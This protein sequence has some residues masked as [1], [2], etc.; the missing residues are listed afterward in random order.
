[1]RIYRTSLFYDMSKNEFK[2]H[3]TVLKASG[4]SSACFYTDVQK[5]NTFHTKCILFVDTVFQDPRCVVARARPK[6]CWTTKQLR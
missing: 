1:M 3:T 5:H 4:N 6:H 2:S